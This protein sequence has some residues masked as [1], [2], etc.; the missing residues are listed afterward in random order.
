MSLIIW[1]LRYSEHSSQLCKIFTLQA[2]FV[3]RARLKRLT[4]EY[5]CEV[6]VKHTK[7]WG[8]VRAFR[9]KL[10]CIAC[11]VQL[12]VAH[13]HKVDGWSTHRGHRTDEG[14][15]EI[16]KNA[17]RAESSH[18][19]LGVKFSNAQHYSVEFS[20]LRQESDIG[21][22]DEIDDI[23]SSEAR[24]DGKR[25][26][27]LAENFKLFKLFQSH[28]TTHWR[29]VT[30]CLKYQTTYSF[31]SV[32]SLLHGKYAKEYHSFRIRWRNLSDFEARMRNCGG[33]DNFKEG[34]WQVYRFR[35]QPS[36]VQRTNWAHLSDA[37]KQSATFC[38]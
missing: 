35:L 10:N 12:V 24:N 2:H 21:V 34:S 20:L 37:S 13:S 11:R 30:L 32:V 38:A 7:F 14:D 36:L 9:R 16:Q 27:F 26:G 6:V 31:Y 15:A 3:H 33:V 22:T 18:A 5:Q 17:L 29:S 19:M 8:L 1:P 4:Y 28:Y 23:V 25:R